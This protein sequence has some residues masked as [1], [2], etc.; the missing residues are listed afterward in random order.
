MTVG[1]ALTGSDDPLEVVERLDLDAVNIRPDYAARRHRPADADRRVGHPAARDGRCLPALLE[2]PIKDIAGSAAYAFPD[3]AAPRTIR[4]APAGLEKFGDRRAVVFNL[5]DGFS[6]MRDLLGYENCLMSMLC[7]PEHFHRPAGAARWTTTWQL[8]A[9]ARRR[10]GMEIIATTDDV[11]NATGLL[12]AAADLFRRASP[13][14]SA[15]PSPVTR[16]W[17]TACIKHCDGKIDA[18]VD[19]WIDCGIDCL[20][21]VDPAGGYTLGR[22]K[23]RYGRRICLKGNVDCTGA[24]CSGTPEDV[25]AGSPAMPGRRHPRRRPDPLL[26]Q[27]HP[28]RRQAGELSRHARCGADVWTV[29]VARR[30]GF[31]PRVLRYRVRCVILPRGWKPRLLHHRQGTAGSRGYRVVANVPGECDPRLSGERTM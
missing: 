30:R 13:R 5:R 15:G 3:P 16:T 20:D 17:A 1:R 7:E 19:F 8:A 9:V 21:P 28:P 27:H 26:Q 18:V 10:F 24:L 12:D 4:H 25:A 23:A 6:D 29:C 31:Q 11:A 2:S 14:A 22:M